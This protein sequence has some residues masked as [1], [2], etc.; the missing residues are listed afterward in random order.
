MHRVHALD[1]M[2]ERVGVAEAL[3]AD[4]RREREDGA[5]PG[6]VERRL[7]RLDLDRPEAVHP[8]EVVHTVHATSL[9]CSRVVHL[10]RTAI[11]VVRPWDR[12]R[13]ARCVQRCSSPNCSCLAAHCADSGRAARGPPES[14][15]DL[16]V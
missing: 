12:G 7:V 8:A 4:R 11:G 15:R 3:R 16:L 10:G 13:P 14:E 6:V 9:A 1:C 5:L 2:A